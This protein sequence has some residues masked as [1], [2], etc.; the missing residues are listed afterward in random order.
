[1][2]EQNF[3]ERC[4]G[5]EAEHARAESADRSR[6]DFQHPDAALVD[7][8]F[9]MNGTVAEAESG[10]RA[11]GRFDNGALHRGR[12]AGGCDVDGFFKEWTIQRVGFIE[13]REYLKRSVGRDTFDGELAAGN[14]VLHQDS[15]FAGDLADAIANGLEV[16]R[17]V[18]ADDAAA[19]RQIQRLHNRRIADWRIVEMKLRR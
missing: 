17:I 10:D 12:F 3:F 18:Y 14:E 6:G 2:A 9:G 8:H 19:G 16:A 5:L 15:L 13:K 4:A 1:M 11:L 7:A